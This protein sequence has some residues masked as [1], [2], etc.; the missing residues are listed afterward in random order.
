MTSTKKRLH[1]YLEC[2][3]CKIKAHIAILR[4][5]S[6]ILPEFPHRFCPDFHQIKRFGGALAPPPPK[7]VLKNIIWLS[8]KYN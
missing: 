8:R 6:H 4:R 1:F 7:P 2:Y 3:F 5:Y